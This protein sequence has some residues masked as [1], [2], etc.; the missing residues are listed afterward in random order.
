MTTN[1]DKLR[2]YLKR[3]ITDARQAH[4]RLREVE[5]EKYEPIAVVSMSCR[6][7]GG[8]RSPEDL[9]RLVEAGTDAV[10][11]FPADR[12]WDVENLY[13]P[14]P[15]APGRIYAEGGGFLDDAGG[16]DAGF[17]GISPREALAMDPQQRLLLE[18]SWEA[19]ERAGI[20]PHSVRGGRVGVF[21]GTSGQDYAMLAAGAT[22]DDGYLA[23]GNAASVVSGRI[24]YT[25]GLEGPAVTVDTACS[26]S[27]VAIHLAA[28]SL[29]LGECEL[30]LAGG[31]AVVSTP[32]GLVA[33]SRQRGLARDGRCK[34]F[35]AAADGFGYAE[36]VGVLLLE[37]LSDAQKKGHK[38]LGVIRGSAVNQDGASNGLTAPN[39][40]SQQRVIRQALA[41][42]RITA[43]DVDTVE[44]HGTGTKLGDPIEAQALLA[45]YGKDDREQPLWLGSLKSNIGHAQAAAG[46][47]GVIKMVQA[48]RHGILPKT[49][50]ADEPTP[51][52]DWSAGAVELLAEARDWPEADRPRR[53]GVSS[54]GISGTNA[55]VILEQAPAE[56]PAEQVA[57][58]R[59]LPVVPW[60]LSAKSKGAL[61]D[62]AAQLAAHVT[63]DQDTSP[64]DVALSLTVS[65]TGFD[66]RAVVIGANRE[67]L[68]AGLT[69]V[70]EGRPGVISGTARTGRTAFLFTGQGAQQAGMGRELYD[71]FPV[72]ADALDAACA[73]LD[74]HLDWPL[75]DVMFAAEDT[76]LDQTQY[77]QAALFAFETALHRLVTSWGITP[78]TLAGHSIGELTAAH[79]AG[80]WTLDD[81]ARVVAA[82]GRLMQA[83]PA[84]GAMAAIEATE[85]EITPLLRGQ[86]VIAAVNGPTSTVIS[87]D[88]QSVT[89]ITDELSAQGRK[90]KRLTVSHAFHS[91]LMEPMLH[92]FQ[93]ILESV[94]FH[95]PT[96]PIISNLTGQPADPT[97]LQTPA[98]WV[99]HIREAVRF[100]DTLRTLA[101]QN[102]TRFLEIGPDGILTALAQQNLDDTTA[103]AT[104]TRKHTGPKA[105]LDAVARLHVHGASVDWTAYLADTGAKTVDLPTYPFQHTHYWLEPNTAK[106]TVTAQSVPEDAE[107]ALDGPPLAQQLAALPRAEQE[108]ALLDLVR[109]EAAGV[110]GHTD[111]SEVE[112]ESAFKDLGFDSLTSVEFRN[113]LRAAIGV[114]LPASLV[115]DHPAPQRL[116]DHLWAELLGSGEP[117]AAAR[118]TAAALDEPVAIVSMSC[119]YPGGVGSPEELWRLVAEGTDAIGPFPS[120]RGWDIDSLYDP[121]PGVSG[122]TYVREAGFLHDAAEFDAEFFGISPREALA[123]DPQQRLL[124]E[125]SWEAFERAGIDPAS[126]RGSQ[127]GVYAGVVA[128]DYGTRL[129]NVPEELEGYLSSGGAASVVSGRVSY[130]FGLEG[131][132]V[133]VDTACSSSL[134]A[135]HLAA[136]SLRTGECSMAL[137]GGVTVMATPGAFLD[138][139][140]QRGLA[141][142]GRCKSF[143]AEADGTIWSEGIGVLL[144][145]R[146]S[147][148]RR[149]G[150]QVLGVIRGSAVNQDGASNGLSA[151]NGPSQQ[152]VIRQALANARLTPADVDAVEAHGT[153]TR[154]GDPIEAQALLATYGKD[155]EQPLWLG[156][157]KSNIGH[158]LAAAGVG[159]VIKMVQAMRH[160]VLPKTLHADE[161]TPHVDWSAG[162]VELLAEARDWPEADRPRRAGVSSFGISGTNA[163]IIVEQAPPEEQ[164]EAEPVR[165]LPVTP[166]LLSAKSQGALR[167][168]AARL[169]A[170]LS[171]RDHT[172]AEV[173]LSLATTRARLDQRA[174]VIGG[175]REELIAGLAAVAEGRPGIVTGT[176]RTG[177]TA[178]L[179][180]G[181]GAQRAG[182]GRELYDAFPVFADALDAVCAALDPYLDR[183][184]KDV[185]FTA[186]DTAL[187]QTQYTQAALFAFETALHR[188][189]TSWGI[190]PDTLAGH[191]IGELTAA[192]VAGLW[193]LDD[194]ARVV[195][196]RGRLMQALPAGGAMAAIEATEDEITPLLRGQAV[197]AAV[198]G[199]TSTVISGDEESV[200]AVL[201]EL[202]A[203]GR[204]VKQLTV[205]HA[206]HSPL[207]EPMLDDFQQVLESVEFH[208]PT[209]PIISNLTGQPADPDQLA[210]PAYW[211]RHVREAVRFHDSLRTLA[212]Q[213]TTRFLEIG[214]DGILTALAADALED[215]ASI[216]TQTRKHSGPSAL[217][218]ALARLH[219]HGTPVDWTVYLADTGARTVDLPTYPFQHTHYWLESSLQSVVSTLG[220]SAA[221]PVADAGE[222]ARLAGLPEGERVDALLAHVREQ[223][224][225][226]LGYAD[227]G[228]VVA[229]RSFLESGFDSLTAVELRNRLKALT[230]LRLGA[231]L[232]FDH[233]TPERLAAY[234]AEQLGAREVADEAAGEG[235]G[236]IG[237]LYWRA[238]ELG[239]F[240]EAQEVL[241]AAS[242]LQ[243]QFRTPAEGVLPEPVRLATGPE[244][245][246]GPVLVCFPSFS[247]VAG[248][249]EYARFAAYFR[250]VRDVWAL[251]EPG[252]VGGE[253][254]PADVT[255]LAEAHAE[256]AL[257]CAAGRPFVLV[258]RS[259]G[260]WV[261][262]AVAQRLEELGSPAVAMVLLDSSSPSAMQNSPAATE[263]AKAMLDRENTFD[264]LSDER[265]SAMGGY[266]RVF[267][268]WEPRGLATR[269]LL[270]RASEHFAQEAPE[271][272]DWRADW[273]FADDRLDVP[274][275]HFTILED[276]SHSTAGAAHGWLEALTNDGNQGENR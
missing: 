88:E 80:L 170:H 257:R 129:E 172:P 6:L 78:D 162:A 135:I 104:Q 168:Q 98:Y 118:V 181:Q 3:A 108:R 53:A 218:E 212:D 57:A 182:M 11:P 126:L 8:V 236:P 160:G 68:V 122:R 215:T 113:R 46:V 119:R 94:E 102:T 65:R 109:A 137:A 234:L 14:D 244:D 62:Q 152:R 158:T 33:F 148:A 100:H 116:A 189:V 178:F 76:A 154:L 24:S 54:F 151:P 72:F 163:H 200:E 99:R 42:A 18:T 254:L 143:A 230:G 4:R 229:Q 103:A 270:I 134:V 84:G 186:E 184:L 259:A 48:M 191:S 64:L 40:P 71:A 155:R 263:M 50:H 38:V 59:E 213:N 142:D 193:T 28:Q 27:L 266:I 233:P 161:P 204:K 93:H 132:A 264:L 146:L 23:I 258:G 268:G 156:S 219:V 61:R 209:L 179:F 114:E 125:A 195:A 220:E 22:G 75:K 41:N 63:G 91:P 273:E 139:S 89:A 2:E 32:E 166:W 176:A 249:H 112:P 271:G 25:L 210:T 256:A 252:F 47:A 52:V 51:H 149:R 121:D 13:D 175:N 164:P 44:A 248:P 255:A 136:Q 269:T 7:P 55:H 250:D 83:L 187:D 197:I 242:L 35:S 224:A 19:F 243:E 141:P 82:R 188:L 26:S 117:Q 115:F 185:M 267:E 226:V 247:P 101:D 81:A 31:V 130:T 239:K 173:A 21:A 105:L 222:A 272:D 124:L 128:H 228:G 29:R 37:R 169:A 73:A 12:G 206:F 69:A 232:M 159:G 147:D 167:E 70:A 251:P 58:G 67:E 275:N 190:T 192:H 111:V 120:D 245:G 34:A 110:L 208:S 203:Q 171:G 144:L 261:A 237:S 96:L 9:W 79:V 140:R 198:N 211:V 106:K 221:V 15:D 20:D 85:Q 241:K 133:T 240:D 5:E 56:E 174:V 97:D 216:A 49:L 150:H 183:P 77:T 60:V 131:P 39:G 235:P 223:S 1:E 260:G 123:M 45:T 145:E 138:F 153:G 207:M 165:E 17:F 246:D 30:A 92:D 225:A 16:F 36:G 90:V 231:T 86:A 74:A 227:A 205:S 87:G 43:A 10:G 217:V 265:L 238:C 180:T 276:L 274:G 253:S 66:Q 196:A 177:R 107:A 95:S 127:T 201:A 194:A 199:P 214:P 202:S 157:L 262:H